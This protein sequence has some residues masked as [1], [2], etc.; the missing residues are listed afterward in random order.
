MKGAKF[1]KV[2]LRSSISLV[3]S[4][5]LSRSANSENLSIS[6]NQEHSERMERK[7]QCKRSI[8]FIATT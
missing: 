8:P 1:T 2:T 5:I 3:R 4:S 7:G 6:S